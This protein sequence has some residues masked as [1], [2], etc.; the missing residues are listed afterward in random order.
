MLFAAGEMLI[1]LLACAKRDRQPTSPQGSGMPL[2]FHSRE[3]R[4][5]TSTS[6]HNSV[7]DGELKVKPRGGAAADC[8]TGALRIRAKPVGW[9]PAPILRSAI[10]QTVGDSCSLAEQDQRA[11]RRVGGGIFPPPATLG[12][13]FL[14]TTAGLRLT[15]PPC[16]RSFPLESRCPTGHC[17]H[18]C[19]PP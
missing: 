19:Q 16:R 1:V 11:W 17:R 14:P 9:A 6:N 5:S 15:L 3:L 18:K 4:E 2:V 7:S 13:R 10:P 12:V 8:G